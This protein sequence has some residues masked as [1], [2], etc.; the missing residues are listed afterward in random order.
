MI[1]ISKI[2]FTS[3]G[4][5]FNNLINQKKFKLFSRAILKKFVV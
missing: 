5:T 2:Y 1:Q 3:K 4:E